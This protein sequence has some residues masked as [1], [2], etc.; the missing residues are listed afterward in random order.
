MDSTGKCTRREFVGGIGNTAPFILNLGTRWRLVARLR[1][2]PLNSR[3]IE[4]GGPQ[5]RSER[6][7]EQKNG[8][9]LPGS[10]T[11]TVQPVT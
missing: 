9:L 1:S 4:L 5:N 2:H 6:V 11:R 7:A 10:E 8:L 3:G